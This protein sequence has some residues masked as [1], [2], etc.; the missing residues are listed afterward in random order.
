MKNKNISKSK[1]PKKNKETK[2]E[3]SNNKDKIPQKI[4][5]FSLLNSS[6]KEILNH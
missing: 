5:S 4:D 1:L 6:I 2:P 3:K